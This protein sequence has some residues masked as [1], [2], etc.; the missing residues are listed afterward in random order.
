MD[1]KKVDSDKDKRSIK[2]T[3]V[4]TGRRIDIGAFKVTSA[5]IR[6][7][8]PLTVREK[9]PQKDPKEA[10]LKGKDNETKPKLRIE[11]ETPPAQPERRIPLYVEPMEFD[12]SGDFAS[13]L[14]ESEENAASGISLKIGDRVSGRVI[15]IGKDHIFISLGPKLEAA[16]AAA[17]LSD[18]AGQ[19]KVHLGEK[20]TS[21]VISTHD[22]VT[23]SNN[24]AQ[25][26]LDQ[27]MLEEAYS[28]KIP[29]EGKVTAI[30]K[31]G[32]DVQISGK[33]AFCPVGQI[34]L[35]FVEDTNSFIGRT[36]PFLIERI[37]D[38]GRNIVVSR[39]ALLERDR[40]EKAIKTINDLELHK[41]YEAVIT[42]IADFG[43]FA[44]IGGLEGL[45]PRSEIS[46]GRIERV[47]DV[48]SSGDQVEVIVLSFDINKDDPTKSKLS[49]S[50]KKT[51]DDPYTLH[52]HQIEEGASLEGRV[53]RLESF[54]AFIELFP[55]IDGLIHISELS[56]NRIAHPKEVLGVGDPVSVRVI[57]V[58]EEDKRIGL[59]LRESVSKKGEASAI[60]AKIERGQKAS[61]TVS[62]IERYGVFLQL[63]DGVT[64]LLPQSEINLPKNADFNRIFKIGDRIDVV[65]IDVDTQNRIRV[66]S[67]ARTQ[68]DERDSY[69]QFQTKEEERGRS[70]G[71]LADLLKKRA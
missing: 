63:N 30:N 16:I 27:A 34:D 7:R 41:K 60:S 11:K 4:D 37:E 47:S 35:K 39:R 51:K 56:E 40:R 57:S 71:T 18:E 12:D 31:G 64:A 19:P 9:E 66:S 15:H 14:A 6:K 20:L 50:L 13:M 45:I 67:L 8:R 49:F 46:H 62:R 55:G 61:G 17:E 52:W 70:F 44:D 54:G 24:V 32:F 2:T 26:G 59:S 48:V 5:I 29:V 22:G 10:I 38:G 58:N 21:Y 25:S 42:R 65:I 3:A 1:S 43:A 53:V 33:R 68:M 69:L 36:L 28:K 23:L